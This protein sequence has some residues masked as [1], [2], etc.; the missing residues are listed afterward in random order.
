MHA[1]PRRRPHQVWKVMASSS[2]ARGV[3]QGSLTS[4]LS[5]ISFSSA[6][7][8]AYSASGAGVVWCGVVS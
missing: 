3:F 8:R 4:T 2:A 1:Q 6:T 7:S 5:T